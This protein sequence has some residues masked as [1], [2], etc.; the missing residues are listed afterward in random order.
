MIFIK[1]YTK[2]ELLDGLRGIARFYKTDTLR[3]GYIKQAYSRLNVASHQTY[4]N[5]FGTLEN[6]AKAAELKWA[7]SVS[8]SLKK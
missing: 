5:Y 1:A 2:R 4:R 7:R 8:N 3:P 6:A